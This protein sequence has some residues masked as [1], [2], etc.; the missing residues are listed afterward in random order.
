MHWYRWGGSD[1]LLEVKLQPGASRSEFAGMH[2]DHLKLRIHAP[3]VDG[4]A[5][6]ALLTFIADAFAISK[7]NIQIERGELG[8]YKILR[9][10]APERLPEALLQLGLTRE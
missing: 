9:I 5:N 4:K 7:S 1:L 8:R 6:A 2:G 3:A 10:C